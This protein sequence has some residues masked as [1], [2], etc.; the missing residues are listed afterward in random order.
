MLILHKS[1]E[2]SCSN[3]FISAVLKLKFYTKFYYFFHV[4]SLPSRGTTLKFWF[5]L[6][7]EIDVVQLFV[8]KQFEVIS[9]C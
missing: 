5:L 7:Q 8:V 1:F 3:S 9:L 2:I 6:L 4:F